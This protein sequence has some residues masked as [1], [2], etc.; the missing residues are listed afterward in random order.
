MNPQDRILV[1]LDVSTVDDAL[2][3]A[4]SLAGRVGGLKVGLELVNAAGFDIFDRLRDAGA[5]R[6][7]YDAKFHDIPNTVAGAVRAAARRGVWMVNVH[8]TGGFKMMQAAREAADSV[9][10]P[11]LLIAVTVLTS[12]DDAA[13]NEELRVPGPVAEHVE[14]LA[15]LAKDT[16]CDGVVASPHEVSLIR[17]ACGDGFV[18]VIPGVRPKGVGADDQARVATPGE[19]VR[20]GAHYLVIGRAITRADDPARAAEEIAAEIAAAAS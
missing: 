15:L 12:I 1:A 13:L 10:K 20:A 9:E 8:A 3:L 18:T 7:F 19:A 2:R 17:G 6:I 5:D 16:R 11:P 14:H 4:R